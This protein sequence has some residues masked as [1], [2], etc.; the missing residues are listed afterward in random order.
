L[1]DSGGT[2]T[3]RE[4]DGINLSKPASNEVTI[5]NTEVATIMA[6]NY[7]DAETKGVLFGDY[8]YT[9]STNTMGLPAGVKVKR[10]Y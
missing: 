6:D 4:G 8:F 3:I 2:V 1:S 10:I 7:A 5:N 9:S